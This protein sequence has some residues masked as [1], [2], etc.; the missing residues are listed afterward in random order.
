MWYIWRLHHL[1]IIC[2]ATQPWYVAGPWRYGISPKFVLND[3]PMLLGNIANTIPGFMDVDLV[4]VNLCV[5]S[6]I[7]QAIPGEQDLA[8]ETSKSCLIWLYQ[9]YNWS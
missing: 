8:Q 7:N 6:D 5:F 2:H 1:I 9:G 3:H 4:D